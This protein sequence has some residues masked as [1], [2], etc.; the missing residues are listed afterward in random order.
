[1]LRAHSALGAASTQNKPEPP[2]PD[3]RTGSESISSSSDVDTFQFTSGAKKSFAF[4]ALLGA[5]YFEDPEG[6]MG[7]GIE[8][9]N[10]KRADASHCHG[11]AL[12]Y[13]DEDTGLVFKLPDGN[14]EGRTAR[15][16]WLSGRLVREGT[17]C[18]EL[19][20]HGASSI[21]YRYDLS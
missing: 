14:F 17:Y 18:V 13:S 20:A 4:T 7:F 3:H 1:M 12:N 8:I 5:N 9:F 19:S 16:S 6:L 2:R 21:S 15:Q 10:G 11:Q